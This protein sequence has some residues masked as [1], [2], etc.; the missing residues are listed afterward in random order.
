MR[1]F[2]YQADQDIFNKVMNDGVRRVHRHQPDE[3]VNEGRS[4]DI[5]EGNPIKLHQ[6]AQALQVEHQVYTYINITIYYP[7]EGEL[8]LTGPRP[9]GGGMT[10]GVDLWSSLVR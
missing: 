5:F 6:P 7:R 8:F 10:G 9:S 4:D 2:V 1:V 3:S